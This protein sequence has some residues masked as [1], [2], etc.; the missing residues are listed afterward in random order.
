MKS[1]NNDD[2]ILYGQLGQCLT[3][4]QAEWEQVLLTGS[5]NGWKQVGTYAPPRNLGQG[6]QDST[7][8]NGR[9]NEP[10][11]QTMLPRDV[12]QLWQALTTAAEVPN[13]LLTGICDFLHECRRGGVLI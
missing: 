7:D 4:G 12:E 2:V 6:V 5:K 1:M 9:Y 3:L 13:R 11:G 10:L 8:W